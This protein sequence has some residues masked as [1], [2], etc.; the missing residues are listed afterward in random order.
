MIA[1][2]YAFLGML[3]AV[4]LTVGIF[5]LIYVAGQSKFVPYIVAVDKI[6]QPI[7]VHIAERASPIDQ[8]V[9]H[10]ELANWLSNARGVVTA[11]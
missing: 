11:A 5:G 9:V 4:A 1:R 2:D 10:S 3:E 6:G 7:S 8:R